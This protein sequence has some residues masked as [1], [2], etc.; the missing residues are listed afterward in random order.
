MFECALRFRR[1]AILRVFVRIIFTWR[2]TI[3]SDH[4]QSRA[5]RVLC[6]TALDSTRTQH[7]TTHHSIP[8][9]KVRELCS[10][11]CRCLFSSRRD[12]EERSSSRRRSSNWR[13]HSHK[14]SLSCSRLTPYPASA[15]VIACP[16]R[17][18]RRECRGARYRLS[19]L[20]LSRSYSL[21]RAVPRT[22]PKLR[23]TAGDSCGSA[24]RT[25]GQR[26]TLVQRDGGE[27][28]AHAFCR[29]R[30][31]RATHGSETP[32]RSD[33]LEGGS[34]ARHTGRW[35]TRAQRSADMI[36]YSCE[37]QINT[38]SAVLKTFYQ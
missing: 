4:S 29:R 18:A 17:I 16:T 11:N 7:N 2:R 35:Q 9:A 30:A 3:R 37:C 25:C 8:F 34:C 28:R 24:R 5:Q 23:A 1:V 19:R 6:S 31:A 15:R 22:T 21:H 36:Q 12:R 38:L 13:A 27:R 20:T 10:A 33:S 26:E 14:L 32:L